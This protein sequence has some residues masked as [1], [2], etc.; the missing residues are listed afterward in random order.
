LPHR[1]VG[2][3]AVGDVGGL[4]AH[5]TRA[6]TGT[7]AARRAAT[8][9]FPATATPSWAFVLSEVRGPARGRS[10]HLPGR[11]PHLPGR[12]AARSP[13]ARDASRGRRRSGTLR[14]RGGAAESEAPAQTWT[15][16]GERGAAYVCAPRPR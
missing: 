12:G 3:D 10:P 9:A 5:S 13:G 2:E 14:R 1:R 4:V 6:A 16:L 15:G 8:R 7:Q 11:S